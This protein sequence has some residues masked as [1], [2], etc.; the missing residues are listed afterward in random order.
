MAWIERPYDHLV[1]RNSFQSQ[2]LSLWFWSTSF[3]LW[4]GAVITQYLCD[5]WSHRLDLFEI[6]WDSQQ[7]GHEST[8][9]WTKEMMIC[10]GVAELTAGTYLKC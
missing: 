3:L 4:S 5:A 2:S 8:N 10:H 1:R 6:H 9:C 7:V